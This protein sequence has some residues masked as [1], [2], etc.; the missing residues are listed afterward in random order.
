MG[1]NAVLAIG[2]GAYRLVRESAEDRRRSKRQRAV[3]LE[4]LEAA[5]VASHAAVFL[6]ASEPVLTPA[7][8]VGGTERQAI[9][10]DHLVEA[11]RGLKWSQFIQRWRARRWARAVTASKVAE[12][13]RLQAERHREHHEFRVKTWPG[14]RAGDPETLMEVMEE[15][16]AD[17]AA[18]AIPIDCDGKW[19]SVVVLLGT[20]EDL[21]DQTCRRAEGEPQLVK[22][23]DADRAE[24]YA[25]SVA[26]SIVETVREALAVTLGV[27]QLDVL[28]VARSQRRFRRDRLIP[29]C[30]VSVDRVSIAGLDLA[31]VGPVD[32]LLALEPEVDLVRSTPT[33]REIDL[34]SHP[35]A[36]DVLKALG[37]ELRKDP[38]EPGEEPSST[39]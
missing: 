9:F 28:A 14:V 27:D 37:D 35:S 8:T 39:S 1:S 2:S 11:Y 38:D 18:P 12:T 29:L 30:L 19:A 13:N 15:A 20:P 22:R 26:S 7:P 16:F 23:S 32:A 36:R 6:E 31:A 21:P 5:L 3:M 24:L 10:R 4:R 33:F 25:N 34:R 17:N